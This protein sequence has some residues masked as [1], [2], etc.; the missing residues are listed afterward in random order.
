MDQSHQNLFAR[1]RS[2][3][4]VTAGG[5]RARGI[6]RGLT[7]L[8]MQRDGDF[9]LGVKTVRGILDVTAA[10]ARLHMH[11]PSTMDDLLQ[12][13]EGPSLNAL[14]AAALQSDD[15]KGAFVEERSIEYGPVVTRPEKIVCVGLNYRRHAKE[16][17]LPIPAQPV[18][19]SKYNNALSGHDHDIKLPIEVAHKFDYETELVIVIGRNARNV[20]EEDAL[21][22]V[23]G[24]CVGNDLSARDL[25]F[26][27]GGQWL[28]GKTLDRFAPLGP[29]L[30][31]ADQVNPDQLKIECRV[32]GEV[33]QSSNTDDFIFDTAQIVSY[34]SSLIT[35]RAG[36]VIF[37][38]TPE[39]VIL[40]YP[41]EK[42]VWLKPGDKIACSIE[43]LGDLRFGLI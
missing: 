23:A 28:A 34:I 16:V 11:A 33:R 3:E 9:Q 43:N 13:E 40:G 14:V 20:G 10:A 15:S 19:F 7:L 1:A 26:D 38:G 42:Q 2:G 22:Y 25:Q 37:T 41:K 18:L 39:G 4:P 21:S 27:R 36:D 8:T 30:V 17:N 24:Y 31:T 5:E 12:D 6:A 35:L 29:Y 32:N